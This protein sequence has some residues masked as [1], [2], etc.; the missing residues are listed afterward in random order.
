MYLS[1]EIVYLRKIL[2]STSFS[3]NLCPST[4]PQTILPVQIS[5]EI[6]E[7][8]SANY[9]GNGSGVDRQQYIDPST[10]ATII[11]ENRKYSPSV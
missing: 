8:C 10:R 1:A 9:N 6:H 11:F 7:Y 2:L 3:P 4:Y 5:V